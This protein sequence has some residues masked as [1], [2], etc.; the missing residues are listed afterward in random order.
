MRTVHIQFVRTLRA[1]YGNELT[2][3]PEFRR[4]WLCQTEAALRWSAVAGPIVVLN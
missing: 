3:H 2:V 4:G 1:R